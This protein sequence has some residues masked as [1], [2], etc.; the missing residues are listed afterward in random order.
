MGGKPLGDAWRKSQGSLRI[1]LP[2]E[3]KKS[4]EAFLEESG[5]ATWDPGTWVESFWERP[6]RSPRWIPEDKS[7]LQEKKNNLRKLPVEGD[8][9]GD[10]SWF[11]KSETTF[12][13]PHTKPSFRERGM[14][15]AVWCPVLRVQVW[16][17]PPGKD[18]GF[19]FRWTRHIHPRLPGQRECWE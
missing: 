15:K 10:N 16:G 4:R 5:A 12:I 2:P 19:G 3:E 9:T 7:F 14:L 1:K 18:H 6:W 17:C 11:P 8:S 13:S